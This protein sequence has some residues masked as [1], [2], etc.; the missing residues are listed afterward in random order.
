MTTTTTP[1]DRAAINRRNAQKS[2]GPRT[3]EGKNR[4]RFNA[5]KH[6]MTAKTLVLPDEDANVL[7]IRLETWID[8]L[9]PQNEVEQFLVEQAVQSSW[10]LDRAD[11]A[12][13]ARL[14]HIIESVPAEEAN[15]QREEAAALGR[16]LFSDRDVVGDANLQSEILD[17][18]LPGR[19]SQP[20]PAP[21]TSSTTPRPSSAASNPRRPAASGCSTAGPSSATSSTRVRPGRRPRRSK[22]IRLL[23]KQPLDMT[24]EQWENHRERRFLNPDP[25]LDAHY[26]RKLDRQLDDR[27]AEHESAT[28]A[29]LRSV[30]DRAI[31]R[32]ETLAAGHR[33]RAEADA[34][35]QAAILSFDAS[36]EGERLRRYQFSC[37]RSLFRSLDTL[38]KVRRSGLGAGGGEGSFTAETAESKTEPCSVVSGPCS[39]S[40]LV[41]RENRRKRTH[42]PA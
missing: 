29:A 11:R 6:G 17:A 22:A 41:V 10:K 39:A 8:D 42:G 16:R 28:I 27:L 18:L 38:L 33:Q 24:P 30:A 37:S 1:I 5:V 40:T 20:A 15:R 31:A 23:G 32:L 34:A 36:T 14:S 13:V 3:P 4:S 26:D 21:S 35:Q 2:T 9:Q 25:D 19:K 7:Q 12:E